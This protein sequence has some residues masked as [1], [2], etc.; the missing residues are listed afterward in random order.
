M[1]LGQHLGPVIRGW[2]GSMNRRG[3]LGGL[4]SALVAPAI[5]R[6]D[7]IMPVKQ[8]ILTPKNINS[9]LTID[10]ITK[11]AIALFHNSNAFIK[12]IDKQYN[13]LY[14][15]EDEEDDYKVAA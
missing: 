6:I 10:M 2:V 12:N 5:V 7:S 13:Y 3:F 9:L 1:L 4:I 14:D 8:V 15:Y 11:E